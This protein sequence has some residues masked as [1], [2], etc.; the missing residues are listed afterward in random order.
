MTYFDDCQFVAAQEK[1]HCQ[2]HVDRCFHYYCSVE[3]IS[4]GSM[5]MGMDGGPQRL[6]EKPALFWHHPD[7]SYQYG[8]AGPAGWHHW[9][10]TFRGS[11]ALRLLEQGFLPLNP[12]C[13]L[14]VQRLMP[15]LS[16]FRYLI[17]HVTNP[18]PGRHAQAVL[19]L[20]RLLC[21][22]LEEQQ[23]QQALIAH[24]SKII[25]AAEELRRD[26]LLDWNLPALAAELGLSYSHFRRLFR[27]WTGSS[28]G[29]YILDCR[30]RYAAQRLEREDLPIADLAVACGYDPARFSKLFKSRM[31]VSPGRYRRELPG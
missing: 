4:G 14:P 20:E 1:P 6:I 10:V 30:M 13:W 25:A 27:R 18:E 23:R 31:G 17:A 7:H 19:E 29:D 2:A 21:L 9:Y 16:C 24:Q 5:Y 28:P 12:D 8:P 15:L 11:R 3:L 22:A 26:C